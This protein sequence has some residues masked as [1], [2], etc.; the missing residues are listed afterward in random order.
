MRTERERPLRERA[1]DRPLAAPHCAFMHARAAPHSPPGKLAA[2]LTGSPGRPAGRLERLVCVRTV[3]KKHDC[4]SA[5]VLLDWLPAY[6]SG[7]PKPQLVATSG[8]PAG[9]R[10][11]HPPLRKYPLARRT[12]YRCSRSRRRRYKSALAAADTNGRRGYVYPRRLHLQM[13]QKKAAHSQL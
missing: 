5:P 7:E 6:L 9:R 3:R 11:M 1:A 2:S 8:R 10:E 12:C 4:A 13:T